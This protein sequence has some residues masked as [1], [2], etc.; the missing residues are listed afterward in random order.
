MI[1][2]ILQTKAMGARA[3][4]GDGMC[5]R[6]GS[7]N[8]QDVQRSGRV[9][10]HIR[11]AETGQEYDD[12]RGSQTACNEKRRKDVVPN[13]GRGGVLSRVICRSGLAGKK[14]RK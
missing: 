10:H 4:G 14:G 3:N 13:E 5:K 8:M 12:A 7:R 1:Y 11:R 9:Q 2:S 6:G